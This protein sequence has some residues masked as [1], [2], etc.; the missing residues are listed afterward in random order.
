MRSCGAVWAATEKSGCADFIGVFLNRLHR[1]PQ[2]FTRY[3]SS[4]GST[5]FLAQNFTTDA[6]NGLSFHLAIEKLNEPFIEKR[7][8]TFHT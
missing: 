1:F 4:P 6:R 2:F 7:N 8:F 3:T 5:A